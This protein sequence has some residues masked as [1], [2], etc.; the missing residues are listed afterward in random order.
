MKKIWY[1][2]FFSMF[3]TFP[4]WGSRYKSY[5]PAN[6]QKRAQTRIT[7]NRNSPPTPSKEGKNGE[8]DF[9]VLLC[10]FFMICCVAIVGSMYLDIDD[11]YLKKEHCD[12]YGDDGGLE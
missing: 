5:L 9:W 11:K 7:E 3:L 10:G 1:V 12:Y 2:L 4:L 6:A 8:R